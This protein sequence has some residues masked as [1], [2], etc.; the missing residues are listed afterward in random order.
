MKGVFREIVLS[1][2]NISHTTLSYIT[3]AGVGYFLFN[4]NA[5]ISTGLSGIKEQ[6]ARNQ[7]KKNLYLY[8]LNYQNETHDG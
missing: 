1:G 6:K 7:K 5:R 4:S 3:I 8:I 2:T